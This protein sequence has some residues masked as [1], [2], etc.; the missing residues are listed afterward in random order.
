MQNKTLTILVVVLGAIVIFETAYMLGLKHRHWRPGTRTLM[1]LPYKDMPESMAWA[2]PQAYP[3]GYPQEYAESAQNWDPVRET[4]LMQR[5]TDNMFD[6]GF[7]RD[8]NGAGEKERVLIE[9]SINIKMEETAS[10]YLVVADLP[11]INKKDIKVEI[12]GRL[13]TISV[14]RK[15]AKE[16]ESRQIYRQEQDYGYFLQ[17]VTLPVDANP[18]SVT[19]DYSNGVLKINVPKAGARQKTGKSGVKITVK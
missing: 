15:D 6:N 18:A 11:G 10:G 14:E 4:A 1:P 7:T 3:Q 16:T 12:S 9:P 17:T 2:R 19:S 5:Q 13:L 8:Y